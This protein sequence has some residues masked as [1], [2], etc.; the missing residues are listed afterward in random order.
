MLDRCELVLD[1]G[2]GSVRAAVGVP[3][4]HDRADAPYVDQEERPEGYGFGDRLDP[5][6]H[7]VHQH[8]DENPDPPAPRRA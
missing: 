6:Q 3:V 8:V 7:G 4:I 2:L 5:D 1:L